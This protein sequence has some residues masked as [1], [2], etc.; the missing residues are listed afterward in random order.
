MFGIENIFGNK[1]TEE[2]KNEA[3]ETPTKPEESEEEPEEVDKREIGLSQGT[4]EAISARRTLNPD[5][6]VHITAD[7]AFENNQERAA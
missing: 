7:E 3:E 1:K 4:K 5:G 6:T 2:P